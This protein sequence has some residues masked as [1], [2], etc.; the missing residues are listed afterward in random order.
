M[1]PGQQRIISLSK[2]SQKQP[3]TYLIDKKLVFLMLKVDDAPFGLLA[4]VQ[5]LHLLLLLKQ[6][7][8]GDKVDSLF[9]WGWLLHQGRQVTRQRQS[10]H[11]APQDLGWNQR[12]G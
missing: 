3:A 1:V 8:G 5:C 2:L 10:A 9:S 12:K 4:V 7:C 6:L 11:R